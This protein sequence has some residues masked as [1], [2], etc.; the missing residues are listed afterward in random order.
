MYVAHRRLARLTFAVSILTAWLFA[1]F[2]WMLSWYVAGT[3][4]LLLVTIGT[5]VWVLS[6]KPRS[7]LVCNMVGFGLI[8]GNW[9]LIKAAAAV[10]LVHQRLRTIETHVNFSKFNLGRSQVRNGGQNQ[11]MLPWWHRN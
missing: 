6:Y 1:S 2:A 5:A 10:A 9:A 8:V 3:Y 7:Q 4:F 11:S